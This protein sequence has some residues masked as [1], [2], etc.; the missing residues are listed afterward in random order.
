[1]GARGDLGTQ[2]ASS[3]LG[4]RA[5]QRVPGGGLG[6]QKGLCHSPVGG[7]TAF[8]KVGGDGEGCAGEPDE[9]HP[10]SQRPSRQADALEDVVKGWLCFLGTEPLDIGER[11][12]GRVDPWPDPG[13]NIERRPHCSRNE[14]NVGE[15]DRRVNAAPLH[16]FECHLGDDL[17]PLAHLEKAQPLRDCA[18]ARHRSPGL[19]VEPDRRPRGGAPCERA[20][21]QMVFLHRNLRGVCHA[22][23]A[24][25]PACRE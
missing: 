6:A 20:E 14:Q 25:D 18:E 17:R 22:N 8:D 3:H 19:P 23:C 2:V 4:E 24:Y 15:E 13:E 1:M 21:E 11:A 9:R 5:E 12:D 10:L 7:V 16:R